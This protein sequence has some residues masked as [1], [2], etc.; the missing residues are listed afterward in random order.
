MKYA[1]VL[2]V[3]LGLALVSQANDNEHVVTNG[4]VTVD[5]A[6][7]Y[8]LTPPTIRACAYIVTLRSPQGIYNVDGRIDA[9]VMTNSYLVQT[10]ASGSLYSTPYGVGLNAADLRNDTH[11]LVPIDNQV[12]AFPLANEDKISWSRGIYG[13]NSFLG[14][15]LCGIGD[16]PNDYSKNMDISFTGLADYTSI[17]FARVVVNGDGPFIFDFDI[18]D[19]DGN[20]SQFDFAWGVG[21]EPM[22]VCLFGASALVL[23]RRRR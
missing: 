13:P 21:P 19:G 22:S 12:I 4:S 5:V 10:F 18:M 16:G 2:S 7:D 11:L 8:Y 14:T 3:I 20:V 23:I 17:P 15:T 1:L 9:D 6:M